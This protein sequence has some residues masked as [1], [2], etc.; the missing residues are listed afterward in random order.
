MS[1][2]PTGYVLR[3]VDALPPAP[4]RALIDSE[5]LAGTRVVRGR[6]R[7][8]PERGAAVAERL[9]TAVRATDR[10]ELG[11]WHGATL[12][13]FTRCACQRPGALMMEVSVVHPEHRRRGVYSAMARA[14]LA[15]ARHRGYLDVTSLHLASNNPV[16]IAKL[17]LGFTV[18]GAEVSP[19]WGVLVRLVYPLDPERR[20]LLDERIC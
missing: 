1:P 15:E 17:T 18:V 14:V 5:L 11:V 2:L 12:V 19:E 20:A 3:R 13:G 10:L 7:L 6:D 8:P 4:M 16:L 9:A